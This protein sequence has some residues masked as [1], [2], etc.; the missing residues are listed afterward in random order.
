MFAQD[1]YCRAIGEIALA[2]IPWAGGK[3]ANLGELTASGVAVPSGYVIGAPAYAEFCD[4]T[5]LRA[6]LRT[7][8]TGMQPEDSRSLSG[9]A[10]ICAEK[11]RTTPIPQTVVDAIKQAHRTLCVDRPDLPV[12]VRSSAIGEDAEGTS[13]AGMHASFLN[14][15][16]EDALLDAVLQCWMSLYSDRTLYYRAT[17]GLPL[18]EMDIAVVAQKQIAAKRSG[19]MFTIDP[20]SGNVDHL[21]VEASLGLG[22]AIVSGGVSPDRFVFE[23]SGVGETPMLR[24]KHVSRKTIAIDPVEGG[25]TQTRQ[26]GKTESTHAAIDEREAEQIAHTGIQIEAHYGSPQDIE[27][28]LDHAG[29]LWI[30][31][32]RPI[33]AVGGANGLG[34][35]AVGS[36]AGVL[37]SGVGA[38]PGV[39]TGAVRLI[40][41]LD[42][43][44]SFEE[45][46]LL[47]ARTTRPDWVPL[48]RRAAG[49]ITDTGGVTCH[50]AI[51]ARELGIPCV[52]GTANAT[53]TLIDGQVV[54]IDAAAGTVLAGAQRVAPARDAGAPVEHAPVATTR[55]KILVNLSDPDQIER[56]AAMDVDGVGLLRA[57]ILVLHALDG[58]HPKLLIEQGRGEEF[59]ARMAAALTEFASGFSPRPIT[60]RT[61]DFRTNEFRNLEGG[62]RFEPVED[63]PMIGMRGVQRYLRDPEF[64]AL[65]L[66]AIS[67]VWEAGHKNLHMMLPFVRGATELASC[68]ALMA[69]TGLLDQPGFELWVMAE[70]PSILFDLEA[71][72]AQGV[73]GLSVGTNDL[74][75]LLLGAD[76]ESAELAE[77]FD[78]RDP[79]VVEYLRQLIPRARDLGLQ[80]SIC[81][82]APS[83]YPEYA[84]ILVRAGIDAISVSI[85]AVEQARANVA[86]AEAAKA[87]SS[88]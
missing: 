78:A 72:A 35:V 70:V 17:G 59:V 43:A 85:D 52:V 3:G 84:E 45:G 36:A 42:E 62:D 73:A 13:F 40:E 60:Y 69:S 87:E 12:A 58:I 67:R 19:V 14:V 54:T 38:G 31:Q 74:T 8:L 16:G 48:M 61:I 1:N 15:R 77:S 82:Q 81:G 32:S 56:A 64:F 79:A 23:K 55:T 28:A 6:G 5:G 86:L 46:E 4:S 29:V 57:E 71:I 49:I 24:E 76:R 88:D 44:E 21:V 30:L 53:E 83:V 22:E 27:W 75:Q 41:S 10:R 26:L 63:N 47:V 25:G 9:A 50:A 7:A 11:V 2:D 39:A 37:V 33:T 68:R 51:V 80:T 20:A 34:P 66:K 18:A 65:E